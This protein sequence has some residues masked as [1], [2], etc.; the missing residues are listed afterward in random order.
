MP[1]QPG[2]PASSGVYTEPQAR[3][4][5][6]VYRSNCVNCHSAK[7]YTGEDF[8]LAWLTRSA[9]DIFD[10]IST[11]MPEDNPGMLARQEYVDIVAYMLSLN[12]YPTGQRE[13]PVEDDALRLV[14]IDEPPPRSGRARELRPSPEQARLRGVRR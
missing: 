2:T 14:K 5:E 12:G 10:L 7:S 13:L 9:F 6:S 4:G 3:R 1:A 11:L 8:R